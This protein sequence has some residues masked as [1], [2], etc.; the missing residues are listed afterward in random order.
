MILH[1]DPTT[2]IVDPV[3]EVPTLSIIC[4]VFD[5]LT[6]QPYSRD[7]R[8]IAQKAEQYLKSSGIAEKVSGVAGTSFSFR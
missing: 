7:P 6:K 4:N 5:P 8:Y 3:C 1:L 2:A